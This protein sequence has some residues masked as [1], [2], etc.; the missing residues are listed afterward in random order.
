MKTE[1]D[2]E[3]FLQQVNWRSLT[4][5][6][7][8]ALVEQAFF[9]KDREGRFVMQNRRG[10]EYC[11]AADEGETLGRR[12]AD[13]WPDSRADN[14]VEGD[15]MVMRSGRPILNQLAP[16]PEEAGS[17]NIVIYSKFPVRNSEGEV[18]GVAGIHQLF[19]ED[20]VIE[21]RFGR[22]FKAV[23]IMQENYGSDLRISELARS[24]GLS[25]SQFVRRFHSVFGMSPKEYLQRVRVR[26][27][28]RLLETTDST[29]ASVGL[30][31]GF[32][33]HSHFSRAF[34][35]Q[36]GMSPSVYRKEHM[37]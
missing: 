23:R 25:H 2:A 26:K 32:Y 20:R 14:Y 17:E 16:A 33:D 19:A 12:D 9:M 37:H 3:S 15:R 5:E 36:T 31:C 35:T 10:C 6:L 13:Y 4:R 29:V 28:C 27:A 30:R 34:R 21:N 11:N 24:C 18:I 8:D 1:F 7:S 22:L